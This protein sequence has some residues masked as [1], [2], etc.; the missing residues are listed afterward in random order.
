MLTFFCLSPQCS[1][2]ALPVQ[3][4]PLGHQ[5]ACGLPLPPSLSN[6]QVVK[7]KIEHGVWERKVSGG[8]NQ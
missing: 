3:P 7:Y 2:P 5:G 8:R 1:T 4:Q 6:G